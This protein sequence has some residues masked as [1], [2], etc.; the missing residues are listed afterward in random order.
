[1]T[2]AWWTKLAAAA[3][4]SLA[5]A[6]DD[7]DQPE[8]R[9]TYGERPAAG[10]Q[11]YR[12]G[13]HPLHNPE[14]LFEVYQPLI[15]HLNAH[16]GGPKLELEAS[17][18]YAAYEDKLYGRHFAF[19]LPNSLQIVRSLDHG[20]RVFGKLDDDREFRGICLVR[21]DST[22]HSVAGL[23]G[24]EVSYPAPSALAATMLPQAFFFENGLDP[25]TDIVNRYVGS[26]ESS[27]LTVY[28]G[29]VAAGCTWPPPWIKFQRDNPEKAAQLTVKWETRSL[30]HNGFVVRDDVPEDVARKVADLLFGLQDSPEGRALL[31]RVPASRFVPADAAAYEPT[32]QF[33][34]W[35]TATLRKPEEP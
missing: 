20:Y 2:T 19:A 22:I 26:Q 4:L 27:I 29:R 17:R 15:D 28:L 21:R 32:R 14:T 34:D 6:C 16:L 18:S 9:P 12:F 33:V 7:G 24:K 30:P 3:V 25:R 5:W 10:Q 1:M 31:D 8:Y 35:F 13:I 23:K 11:V